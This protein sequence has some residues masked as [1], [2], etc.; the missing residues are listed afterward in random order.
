MSE[1][2]NHRQTSK[3]QTS[4]VPI[5]ARNKSCQRLCDDP[6]ELVNALAVACHH[7]LWWQHGVALPDSRE[8]EAHHH[9]HHHHTREIVV[10][11]VAQAVAARQGYY[12][13]K[14]VAEAAAA[15]EVAEA[16]SAAEQ[17]AEVVDWEEVVEA[18]SAERAVLRQGV[19]V[20]V[21]VRALALD[22]FL[23]VEVAVFL[24]SVVVAAA[25]FQTYPRTLF[26]PTGQRRHAPE[27][28][29]SHWC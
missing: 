25:A 6:F 27:S 7:R 19:C 16:G 28:L 14:Y 3:E 23:V 15:E 9:H 21:L 12:M 10:V 17:A 2:T 11:Q 4:D 1:R 20:P 18:S 8:E 5:V 13:L 24:A 26:V 22:A 29:H